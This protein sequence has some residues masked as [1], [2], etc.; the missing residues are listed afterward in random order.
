MD[1]S[2]L[3]PVDVEGGFAVAKYSNALITQRRRHLGK[4]RDTQTQMMQATGWVL[5]QKTADGRIGR[6]SAVLEHD[7]VVTHE[8]FYRI[9][10]FP[11]LH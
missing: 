6:R 2:D 3:L 8:T 4:I 11:T 1:K 7:P 10:E 5:R 9:P